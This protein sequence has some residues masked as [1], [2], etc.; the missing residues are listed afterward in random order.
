M[1]LNPHAGKLMGKLPVWQTA[2]TK[3]CITVHCILGYAQVDED[4]GV[5]KRDWNQILKYQIC[6]LKEWHTLVC[7][8]IGL[9]VAF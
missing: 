4:S 8:C 9:T 1:F 5:K 3:L 6:L 2:P 7:S